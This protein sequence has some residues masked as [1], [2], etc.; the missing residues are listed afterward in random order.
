NQALA[1]L[2]YLYRKVLGVGLPWLDG[3]VRA[4][5]R[6]RLPTVLSTAEVAAVLAE[7]SGTNGLIAGLLYGSGLRLLEC[8]QLPI[9]DVDFERHAITVRSGKG[10]RDRQTLLPSPLRTELFRH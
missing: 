4:P 8:L 10:D 9:K 1:A 2:L 6:P 3:I 7:L 5:Q